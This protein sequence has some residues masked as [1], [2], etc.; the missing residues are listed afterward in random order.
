MLVKKRYQA[1]FQRDKFGRTQMYKN[2]LMDRRPGIVESHVT[3]RVHKVVFT[4]FSSV[5]TGDE[6]FS[7]F[8]P[9][10]ILQI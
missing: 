1:I 3:G 6:Y 8:S 9:I 10:K 4:S 7:Y 2:I 5:F